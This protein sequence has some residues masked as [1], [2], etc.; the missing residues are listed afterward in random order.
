MDITVPV[1]TANSFFTRLN[2]L[3]NLMRKIEKFTSFKFI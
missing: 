3:W 1:K 2:Q